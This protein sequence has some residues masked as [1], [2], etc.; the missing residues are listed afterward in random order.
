MVQRE[1]GAWGFL[2][3]SHLA[4]G[5]DAVRRLSDVSEEWRLGSRRKRA[6]VGGEASHHP[7]SLG[8]AGGVSVFI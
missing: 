8:G 3:R 4:S 6:R 5:G 1:V 2:V 7:E